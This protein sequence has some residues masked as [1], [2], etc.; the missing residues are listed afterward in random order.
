MRKYIV[1][2]VLIAFY[3]SLHA[4]K[5]ADVHQSQNAVNSAHEFVKVREFYHPDSS[6]YERYFFLGELPVTWVNKSIGKKKMTAAMMGGDILYLN[7]AGNWEAWATFTIDEAL[8]RAHLAEKSSF[9]VVEKL[10]I[11]TGPQAYESFGQNT[12]AELTGVE[13]ENGKVYI[14]GKIPGEPA[15][16]FRV[17]YA[18]AT[19]MSL[20]T[21]DKEL[22]TYIIQVKG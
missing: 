18:N 8:V 22:V 3:T 2:S 12:R 19:R 9:T 21:D 20:C 7:K 5:A 6:L 14:S 4:Q 15:K 17:T 16:R 1:F 13:T 10:H 11:R